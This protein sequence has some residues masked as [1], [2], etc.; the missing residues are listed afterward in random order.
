M[1]T[2]PG[3]NT[4][5]FLPRDLAAAHR[6]RVRLPPGPFPLSLELALR[7]ADDA[8]PALFPIDFTG[9]MLTQTNMNNVNTSKRKVR[10]DSFHFRAFHKL[11]G[12]VRFGSAADSGIGFGPPR[13]D[14]ACS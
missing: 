10:F 9:I 14:R 3:V 11:I 2:D 8:A 1:F 13:S 5:T 7:H 12:S 6:G 4:R